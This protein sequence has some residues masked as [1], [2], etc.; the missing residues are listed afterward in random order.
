MYY[1]IVSVDQNG[2]ISGG[3]LFYCV[4]NVWINVGFI[5][6]NQIEFK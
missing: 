3:V 2:M 1:V 5:C 4:V 6:C